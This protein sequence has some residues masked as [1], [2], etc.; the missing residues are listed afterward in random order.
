MNDINDKLHIVWSV[1]HLIVLD[2]SDRLNRSRYC[3]EM[4]SRPIQH[5]EREF[6]TSLSQGN[7]TEKYSA[8]VH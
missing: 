8:A 3:M 5:A 4:N 7:V 1:E 2:K 6:F